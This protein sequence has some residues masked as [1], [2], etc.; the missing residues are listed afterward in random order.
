MAGMDRDPSELEE[1]TQLVRLSDVFLVGP[2][3]I[4]GSTNQQMPTS[5]RAFLAY[6]GM[7][8]VMFNGFNYLRIRRNRKAGIC[9]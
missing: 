8:T 9:G 3:M 2:A 4:W 5:V 1:F 7:T 6:A